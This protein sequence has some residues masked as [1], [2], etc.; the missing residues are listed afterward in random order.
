MFSYLPCGLS[1]ERSSIQRKEHIIS[2]FSFFDHEGIF[3]LHKINRAYKFYKIYQI[4]K[5]L[6]K[7]FSGIKHSTFQN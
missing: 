2:L 5:I 1:A 7:F 3:F 4:Q 6:S